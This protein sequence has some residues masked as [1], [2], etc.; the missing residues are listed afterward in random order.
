MRSPCRRDSARRLEREDGFSLI[1]LLVVLIIIGLLAAISIA[2]FTG[3][4][5]KAHDAD[6]K[7]AARTAQ[8]AMETYYV[9]HKSYA[10]ASRAEL[11][12]VQPSLRDAPNLD[13]KQATAS[14]YEVETASVSTKPVVFSAKRSADG[15]MAHTC[16]PANTGGCTNGKW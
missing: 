6:A 1:E 2:A 8:I 9:E 16:S 15:T 11:E 14:E 4:Q 3:Q 12:D 7:T 13:I 5:D 10:G